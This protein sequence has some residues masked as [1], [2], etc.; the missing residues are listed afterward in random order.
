VRSKTKLTTS[1]AELADIIE[2]KIS[3][4]FSTFDE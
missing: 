2:G 1:R 3:G 4:T